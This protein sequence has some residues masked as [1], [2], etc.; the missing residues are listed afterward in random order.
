MEITIPLNHWI[1]SKEPNMCTSLIARFMGPAWGP[2]GADRIQVGPMLAPWTLLS[3]VFCSP[4][5]IASFIASWWHQTSTSAN[6]ELLVMS[7]GG[8]H[9]AIYL[10]WSIHLSFDCIWKWHNSL[11]VWCY[12]MFHVLW[13]V[14]WCVYVMWSVIWCDVICDVMCGVSCDLW[15]DGMWY[16]MRYQMWCDVI[17]CE[18]M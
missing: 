10:K 1:V 5:H 14:I 2:S 13:Y 9:H 18:V 17:C 15:C 16:V 3:G 11:P 7:S 4:G 6:I 12:V 8:I